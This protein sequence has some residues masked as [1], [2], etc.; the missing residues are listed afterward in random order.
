MKKMKTFSSFC[1]T[2]TLILILLATSVNAHAWGWVKYEST[3]PATIYP[4]DKVEIQ[5]LLN[6]DGNNASYKRFGYG[7]TNSKAGLTW[8]E[9]YNWIEKVDENNR[10]KFYFTPTSAAT[11][12]WSL[13]IGWGTSVGDDGRYY[14]DNTDWTNN[15]GNSS[16]M[17][18]SVTVNA[19]PKVKAFTATAQST[20]SIVLSWTKNSLNDDVL[21]VQGSST[22]PTQGTSYSNGSTI[23]TG[24]VVYKGSATSTTITDLSASTSYT[25]YIYSIHNSKYYSASTSASATTKTPT[26]SLTVKTGTGIE[27]VTGSTDPVTLNNSYPITAT[28]K[29][30][31]TF[32]KWTADPAA[33][34]TFDNASSANT[35]VTVK[36]G[37]VT[38][39]ASATENTHDVTVSYKYGSTTIK[40][41]TTTTAVGEANAKSIT[42]PSI[43]GYTFKEWTL[44]SGITNK[45]ANTSANPISITTK[46]S[47]NYTLTANY[48][49]KPYY[50]AGRLQQKWDP[51][52]KTQQF[53]Y[54]SNGQYKYETGKTVAELS[55]GWSADNNYLQY[56]FIHTGSGLSNSFT[57]SN[58]NGHNFQQ[59]KGYENALTLSSNTTDG[60]EK[61]IKFADD[62]DN[63]S[64][65]VIWWEP[66]TNKLWY[67]A[68]KNYKVTYGVGNKKGTDAVT[69]SPSITSGELIDPSTSI[70]FSKGTTKAGYTWKNWN[71]KADGTGTNLGTG[72]TYVSSDRTG[73]ISVYA[74][75]DLI[76]YTITYNLNDGTNPNDAPTSYNVTTNDIT[77]PTTPTKTGYTFAGWY[78]NEDCTGEPITTIPQCST[79]DKTFYAK[80]TANTYT[81]TL[82]K[83]EGTDGTDE[84]TVQYNN[85]NYLY[86]SF[87]CSMCGR[88]LF[89]K[90][91]YWNTCIT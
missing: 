55:V 24:K 65:V 66:S 83:Q 25:F 61:F 13:W 89:N 29:A 3:S 18:A 72:D 9:N 68:Q 50:I 81:I 59:K 28:L 75:Y 74:C 17:S 67:T 47:G 77:L 86:S 78:D 69:T 53:T 34:A 54:V 16:F 31:Y 21:I 71:S 80:W 15:D 82:D 45:S 51:S 11:Y 46:A 30:G 7:T 36:N 64:D 35:N 41:N 5:M 23:G 26:N 27:S 2:L 58:Y 32:S 20:S 39:T 91:L 42:A 33:N 49:A 84:V 38:V 40:D 12:Y 10:W 76:T 70:T 1:K 88:V 22:A 79:E 85:N 37:A 52:S 44:G 4:G 19:V 56:F 63:S 8:S 90:T 62:T 6:G 57:S 73:D 60:Q 87:D 14:K 48:T 43:T